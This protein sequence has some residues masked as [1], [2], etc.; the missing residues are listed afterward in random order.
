MDITVEKLQY[1]LE[2]AWAKAPAQAN[3]LRDQMFS[4]EV[5]VRETARGGSV[6]SFSKNGASETYRGPGLGTYT[7]DQL[8]DGWRML[9]NL[10]DSI[11]A[12]MDNAS[13]NPPTNPPAWWPTVPADGDWDAQVY[14]AM[15]KRLQGG[16]VTEYQVDLTDLRLQQSYGCPPVLTW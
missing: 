14:P 10:F 5:S 7:A 9:I 6:G 1:F 2:Y 4:F 13:K 8:G 11:Q 16:T 12:A 15:V 3:T